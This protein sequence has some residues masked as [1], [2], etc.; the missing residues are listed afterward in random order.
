[1]NRTHKTETRHKEWR[2][3]FA[4][5]AIQSQAICSKMGSIQ[6]PS[7]ERRSGRTIAM[8]AVEPNAGSI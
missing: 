8:Y 3:T 2:S 1:L 7:S 4:R 5:T 6:H